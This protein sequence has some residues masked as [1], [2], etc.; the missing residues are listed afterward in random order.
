MY[1]P[2][3]VQVI[4]DHGGDPTQVQ[5][6]GRTP[7]FAAARRAYEDDLLEAKNEGLIILTQLFEK[8]YPTVWI[9]ESITGYM[10]EGSAHYTKACHEL[11]ARAP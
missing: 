11:M 10:S 6:A 9:M 2:E 5:F 1:T 4:L 7:F 3:V 8:T